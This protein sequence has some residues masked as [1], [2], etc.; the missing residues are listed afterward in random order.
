MNNILEYYHYYTERTC[1]DSYVQV[2]LR[3]LRDKARREGRGNEE[4][5]DAEASAA[6]EAAQH[7]M[8]TAIIS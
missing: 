5:L 4:D 1:L 7:I 8:V 3:Q 2:A 6:E